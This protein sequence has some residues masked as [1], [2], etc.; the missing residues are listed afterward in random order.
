MIKR[1]SIVSLIFSFIICMTAFATAEEHH[2]II[3]EN[4]LS[5]TGNEPEENSFLGVVSRTKYIDRW[6]ILIN[7]EKETLNDH[8]IDTSRIAHILV[9]IKN[10]K[11]GTELNADR[12]VTLAMYHDV[13]E[14]ITDDMPT[15]IKYINPEM[16]K[17]YT[18][19]ENQAT[20][21]L[22]NLIEPDLRSEFSSILE[23]NNNPE[24]I[25]LRKIVKYADTISA[26]IKCLREKSMG[27]KDFDKARKNLHKKLL[28][29][30][31]PEVKY[32]IENFLP[33][34]DNT[35]NKQE[36]EEPKESPEQSIF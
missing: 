24:D 30:D 17:I 1:I 35:D 11:F 22:L 19:V 10:I 14:I 25:E 18:Q 2:D 7:Y 8:L 12:A 20:K 32:F 21:S 16:K 9:L 33:S 5:V 34:F 6:G 31:S 27:N 28:Q 26:Y 13:P 4:F 36:C 15:P 29:I 3:K 23:S